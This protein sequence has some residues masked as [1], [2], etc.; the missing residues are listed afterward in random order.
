MKKSDREI[1]DILEA[2]DL[3]KTPHS[4]AALAGCD[5]KTV[6]R[7][8][9]ARDGGADPF[10]P[11]E[12]P[13]LIDPWLPKI[14]EWVEGSHAKVRA[15]VV[16]DKIVVMGY[17]G[18]DRTTRRA[19][20]AAKRS[21]RAGNLRTYRPWVTEPGMWLQFDWGAGPTIGGRA[22]L[23]FC[24]W[25]AWSRF[26]VVIPTWDRTMPTVLTCL[27]ATLRTIGAAPTYVLTDNEKTVTIDRI[28]G[29]PIRHPELVAAGRH[30]GVT[31]RSCEP[32]DPET[33]GGSEATVRIAK[34]DL[35]PTTANLREDYG[36]FVQLQTACIDFCEKVN[37]RIHRETARRP[38]DRLAEE[39]PQLHA[40][41]AEPHTAAL[42]ETRTVGTDQCI[43]VVNVRYSTPPGHVGTQVWQ[44]TIGEELIITARTD[45]GLTEIAR[46]RLALPG[47]HQVD[48][49]HYPNH[50]GLAG[51]QP[52]RPRARTDAEAAF[53]ALGP[54]AHAWLI[55]A[56]AHG[57]TKA[58]AKMADA[59]EL[60]ALFSTD[61]I[62]RALGLAAAAGRFA[63][64][65]LASIAGH[66]AYGHLA[67]E[68]VAV[69]EAH[70]AQPG[71]AAW[72]GLGR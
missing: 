8:A 12:R 65:D 13:S 60:A 30:Y 25:L 63:E 4:A 28:A 48:D 52:P 10:A 19:V 31:V 41:P 62:D 14:E 72:N 34:A 47:D 29:V 20:A 39:L 69:D 33:K 42:G 53:L 7:Y 51:P 57:V 50:P 43:R 32:F 58:R 36:S 40:L 70:S 56:G 71:T 6:A 37:T 27:D 2:F 66:L 18:S 9:A 21:W 38:L 45:R 23:L 15:D 16:H 22:T 26:R 59:V 44:H 1:M 46:H 67:D 35:V 68:L 3:T 54:G 11:I 64:A 17:G 24:A 5:E 61:L 55:E 49:A